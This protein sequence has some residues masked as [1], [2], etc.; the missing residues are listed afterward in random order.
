MAYSMLAGRLPFTG[1][2]ADEL[3]EALGRDGKL[4]GT[5]E[6]F[7]AILYADLDFESAPWDTLVSAD[8]RVSDL[9]ADECPF[10]DDDT[11]KHLKP[12]DLRPPGCR[13]VR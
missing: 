10:G 9:M 2:Y 5:K 7:R 13:V 12:D 1:D 4:R 8:H 6:L 11:D 3:R